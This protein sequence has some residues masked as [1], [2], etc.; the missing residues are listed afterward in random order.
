M[1]ARLA[2]LA[3]N[4]CRLAGDYLAAQVWQRRCTQHTLEQ[5]HVRDFMAIPPRNR[6][7]DLNERYLT[8]EC[9]LLTAYDRLEYRRNMRPADGEQ[10]GEALY[11]WIDSRAIDAGLDSELVHYLAASAALLT[12]GA[13]LGMQHRENLPTW[14]DRVDSHI[15]K[16]RGSEPLLAILDHRHITNLYM[17]GSYSP[18]LNRIDP[19]IFKFEQLGMVENALKARY[20]KGLILK[21]TRQFEGALCVFSEVRAQAGAE[22]VLGLASLAV[23]NSAQILGCQGQFTEALRLANEAYRIAQVSGSAFGVALAQASRR[24]VATRPR[25]SRGLD[26]RVC[27]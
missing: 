8:D 15:A 17:E 19:L 3:W 5:E 14:F 20:L 1:L 6:S 26:S 22:D 21:E 2:F 16:C 4:Q 25:R 18:A 24:G 27:D 13:K 7:R 12:L 23:S 9:V 11:E 10:E